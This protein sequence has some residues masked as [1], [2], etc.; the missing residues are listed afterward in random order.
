M[1]DEV[2]IRNNKLITLGL[3]EHLQFWF[4]NFNNEFAMEKY[5]KIYIFKQIDYDRKKLCHQ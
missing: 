2:I 1:V 3:L 5:L 4:S